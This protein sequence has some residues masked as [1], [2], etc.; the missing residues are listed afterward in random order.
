MKK[1]K[2]N[3]SEGLLRT[4]G[5]KEA[6]ISNFPDKIQKDGLLRTVGSS[7]TTTTSETT[8]TNSSEK[9]NN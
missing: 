5:N 8:S 4:L 6:K 1:E 3:I 7:K 2:I 9:K